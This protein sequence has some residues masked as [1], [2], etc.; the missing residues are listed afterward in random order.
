MGWTKHPDAV[1]AV[2][3]A[4]KEALSSVRK[5]ANTLKQELQSPDD[6][7]GFGILELGGALHCELVRFDKLR[8]AVGG[9]EEVDLRPYVRLVLEAIPAFKWSVHVR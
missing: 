4:R 9:D 8:R 3:G 5:T 1:R 7:N 6:V 2:Q